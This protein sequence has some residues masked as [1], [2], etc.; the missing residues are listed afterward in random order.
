[1]SIYLQNEFNNY[2]NDDYKTAINA[3]YSAA[4]KHNINIFL[5]G[6]I[7]RDI[8][9]N[10]PIKDID[11][12]V[13]GDAVNFCS[14]LK[15]DA[16]FEI[17]SVQENLRTAKVQYKNGVEIDFASTREEKYDISGNL[18]IAYNFGC[19]LENDVKRRDFTI[20]TL[21]L[22]LDKYELV[23]YYNGYNDIL[24]KQIK[25]LHPNSFI[26]DP[27]RIVRALKFML[28]FNFN[29]EDNTQVLMKE[30]LENVNKTMPLERIKN[31]FIQYFSVGKEKIYETIV[32]SNAYKLISDNIIL[33]FNQDYFNEILEYNLIEK[34]D[35][36]LLY[37]LL[38]VFKSD[39]AT[40]RLNMNSYEKKSLNDLRTLYYNKIG[41]DNYSIYKAF[42]KKTNAAIAVYYIITGNQ[43]VIKYLK[44]LQYIK[45][46][47]NGN[48]LINMGFEPSS[49]FNEIF[50][51]ILKSKLEGKISTKQDEI[52][53]VHRF[54]LPE[55]T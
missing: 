44:E 25:I 14:L 33:N 41:N 12:T 21:A 45:P 53:F 26:D 43:N 15:E 40:D 3:A 52:N 46:E 10:N 39:F 23:D 54:I 6:G 47:L 36:W 8:I 13:E 20:N 38:L 32:S 49:I 50:E 30:Y 31:E 17:I 24:N 5:I 51:E 9:M 42:N 29:I 55:K 11:I 7:V 4:K 2:L 35:I 28:R 22:N 19:K 48:D 18:P 1:M 16:E 34:S 37:L 27:S